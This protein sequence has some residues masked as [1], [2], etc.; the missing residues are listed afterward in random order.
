MR[1]DPA[2]FV[3][4]DRYGDSR[5]NLAGR[6]SY[7]PFET[8]PNDFGPA[9]TEPFEPELAQPVEAAPPEP[10]VTDPLAEPRRPDI[11]N[12][13]LLF[14]CLEGCTIFVIM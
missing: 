9:P 14:A 3:A 7:S 11:R 13:A 8:P 6:A 4:A 2:A 10:L 1:V 12:V 5:S